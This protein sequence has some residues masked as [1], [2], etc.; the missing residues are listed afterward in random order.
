M[1]A[2]LAFI[3]RVTRLPA[4]QRDVLVP[5]VAWSIAEQHEGF[6]LEGPLRTSVEAFISQLG[7]AEGWNDALQKLLE[8]ASVTPALL[9]ELQ[10]EAQAAQVVLAPVTFEERK[11]PAAG[12][13]PGGLLAQLAFAKNATQKP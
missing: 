9:Q 3:E 13:A 1:S 10:S 2:A 11:P 4:A 8:A 6:V 7:P 12:Q 5:L